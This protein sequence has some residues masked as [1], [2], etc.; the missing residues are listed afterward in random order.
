MYLLKP[1]PTSAVLPCT[2]LCAWFRLPDSFNCVTY[3]NAFKH[4]I[5][6]VSAVLF[7]PQKE[8]IMLNC[9]MSGIKESKQASTV[10]NNRVMNNF[11]NLMTKY[12]LSYP[13]QAAAACEPLLLSGQA[14]I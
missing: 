10:C 9:A 7:W 6:T 11:D 1:A 8:G 12:F 4:K 3:T 14:Q 5:P 2:Y 13:D